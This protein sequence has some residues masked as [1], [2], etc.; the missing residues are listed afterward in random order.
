MSAVALASEESLPQI[1]R[2]DPDLSKADSNA[3]RALEHGGIVVAGPGLFTLTED[4]LE[5]LL[6]VRQSGSRFHKNIAF[7]PLAESLSGA[8]GDARTSTR[9]R[10][11]FKRYH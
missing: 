5:F 10:E 11:I 6:S 7:H 3:Q 9:L 8:G 4:E 1:F 2:I